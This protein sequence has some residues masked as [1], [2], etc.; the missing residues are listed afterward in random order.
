MVAI[1]QRLCGEDWHIEAQNGDRCELERGREY[2][3][4]AEVYEDDTVTV[5]TNFWVRAPVSIFF[6]RHSAPDR[7]NKE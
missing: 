7:L 5:F 1:T 6:D 4:T 2:T 3:T